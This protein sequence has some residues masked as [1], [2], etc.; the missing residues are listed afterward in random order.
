MHYTALLQYNASF[1]IIHLWNQ[2]KAWE[3]LKRLR[4]KRSYRQ[5]D[6]AKALNVDRAYIQ[7]RKWS[8][9]S[10]SSTLEKSLE[11]FG[12]F[13]QELYKINLYHE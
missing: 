12:N 4:L 9:E 8:D 5:G 6:L 11:R 1:S 10:Y 7:Y 2:A 3:N 13:K